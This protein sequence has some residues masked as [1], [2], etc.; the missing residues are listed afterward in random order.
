MPARKKKT[1]TPDGREIDATVVPFRVGDEPWTEYLLED[2]TVLRIRL[3]T[4]EVLRLDGE[5]DADGAPQ[6]QAKTQAIVSV[7]APD[8]LMKK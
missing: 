8:S 7:S 4:S 1:R 2:G 5:Y 3:V 6:Y